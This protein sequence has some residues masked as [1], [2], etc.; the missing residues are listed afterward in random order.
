MGRKKGSTNVNPT[1]A[2]LAAD[3]KKKEAASILGMGRRLRQ[4]FTRAPNTVEQPTAE[5]S[6]SF[7][8]DSPECTDMPSSASDVD[9]NST[10]RPPQP[11][12]PP[13]RLLG[14][15]TDMFANNLAGMDNSASI[16]AFRANLSSSSFVEPLVDAS[17]S[18][19]LS[20]EAKRGA[21]E[22]NSWVNKCR[23]KVP[24][25]APFE[26]SFAPFTET[27]E[28]R[29][30][31][32]LK[33]AIAVEN[34][35]R[36]E[37]HWPQKSHVIVDGRT[38]K[39]KLSP[40]QIPFGS[41]KEPRKYNMPHC[42]MCQMTFWNKSVGVLQKHFSSASH[43]KSQLSKEDKKQNSGAK[44]NAVQTK[45]HQQNISKLK[46]ASFCGDNPTLSF[47]IGSHTM[48]LAERIYKPV[49][50]LLQEAF[51]KATKMQILDQ[52]PELAQA[53]HTF[54]GISNTAVTPDSLKATY[55]EQAEFLQEQKMDDMRTAFTPVSIAYAHFLLL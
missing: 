19:I 37:K 25:E 47:E 49:Q 18:E 27:E 41:S 24:D 13:T 26:V 48:E 21:V 52:I 16:V 20:E 8:H 6:T 15:Q 31:S 4:F 2:A 39:F 3:E 10:S 14:E 34:A 38:F 9:P 28:D 53:Y 7:K 55:C 30:L 40:L 23:R 42:L 12:Q 5:E 46:C 44:L 33:Q 51:Q 17:L 32:Q 50:P 1:K 54:M 22:F 29:F 43:M 36:T 45:V 35:R 11:Q